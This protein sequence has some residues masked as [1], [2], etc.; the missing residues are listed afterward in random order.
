[1]EISKPVNLGGTKYEF[2]ID[3][4]R[5]YNWNLFLGKLVPNLKLY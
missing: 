2:N 3:I 5:F 4:S 1:M